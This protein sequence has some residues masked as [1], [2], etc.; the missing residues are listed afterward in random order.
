M[1]RAS[2]FRVGESEV[3][4]SDLEVEGMK[5]RVVNIVDFTAQITVLFLPVLVTDAGD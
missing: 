5:G 4:R 2:A 3:I 1:E